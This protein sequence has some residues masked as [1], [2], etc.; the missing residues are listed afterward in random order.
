MGYYLIPKLMMGSIPAARSKD[1]DM[2]QLV[3]RTLRV[4]SAIGTS[5]VSTNLSSPP[6]LIPNPMHSTVLWFLATDFIR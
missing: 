5:P 1:A 4:S 6:L 2:A 3:E